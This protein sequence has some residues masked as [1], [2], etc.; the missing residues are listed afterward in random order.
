MTSFIENSAYHRKNV[1]FAI[2]LTNYYNYEKGI[3]NC[4]GS[5]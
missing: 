1:N 3:K 2:K 4:L 5:T